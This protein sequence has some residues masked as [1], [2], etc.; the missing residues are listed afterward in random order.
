MFEYDQKGK[1]KETLVIKYNIL[2]SAVKRVRA[3]QLLI[4]TYKVF[5]FFFLCEIQAFI[6]SVRHMLGDVRVCGLLVQHVD[7]ML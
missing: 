6:F 7:N 4:S 5:N 3:I 1:E 2:A